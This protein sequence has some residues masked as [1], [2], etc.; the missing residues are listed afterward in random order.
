MSDIQLS[1][2]TITIGQEQ[3]LKKSQV[4]K[5]EGI[6]GVREGNK[7]VFSK[8]KRFKFGDDVYFGLTYKKV[9][10]KK[11]ADG[12]KIV[13]LQLAGQSQKLEF[14]KDELYKNFGV[15]VRN[16]GKGRKQRGI[17]C[18]DDEYKIMKEILLPLVRDEHY[19]KI[20]QSNN[21]DK[22]K[23]ALDTLL[24]EQKNITE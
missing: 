5:S 13:V 1:S 14:S 10:E 3:L 7:Y 4:V 15:Q 19:F 20:L 2:D 22:I 6:W 16:R 17:S 18:T 23:R 11:S 21:I 8:S 9:A 24:N 12:K